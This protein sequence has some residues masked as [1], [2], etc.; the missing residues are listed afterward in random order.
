[1]DHWYQS[2]E[3]RI[4]LLTV[5]ADFNDSLDRGDT[6]FQ[7]QVDQVARPKRGTVALFQHKTR[8]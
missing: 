4:T 5:A 7:E 3:R 1:M 2:S 8:H 6:R